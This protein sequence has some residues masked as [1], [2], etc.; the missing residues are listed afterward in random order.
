MSAGRRAFGSSMRLESDSRIS[1]KLDG[2]LPF[3]VRRRAGGGLL[4]SVVSE[5]LRLGGPMEVGWL[6]GT[7]CWEPGSWDWD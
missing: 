6:S 7:T 5:F 3:L 4:S 1:V 2:F